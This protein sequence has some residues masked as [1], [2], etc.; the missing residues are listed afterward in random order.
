MREACRSA[1]VD[2]VAIRYVEAHGTGTPIG[3]PIEARALGDALGDGRPRGAPCIVGSVKT[4]IG[5][6]EAGAGIAGII[7][8]ALLLDRGEIPPNLHFRA[9]ESQHRLRGIEAAGAEPLRGSPID[10][11]QRQ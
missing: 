5:H 11:K 9:A 10:R 4:N 3:D 2:P 8:L 7:K 6:L 1:G